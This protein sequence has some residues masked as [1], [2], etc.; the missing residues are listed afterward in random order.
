MNSINKT[1]EIKNKRCTMTCCIK[2]I[3]MYYSYQ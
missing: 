2:Y 1:I 3:K